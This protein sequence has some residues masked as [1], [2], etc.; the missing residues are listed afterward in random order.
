VRKRN[1]EA[2]EGGREEDDDDERSKRRCKEIRAD[3]GLQTHE[4]FVLVT[5]TSNL[6]LAP[7][8][9]NPNA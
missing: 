7:Q 6:D 1:G 3:E 8:R 9:L 2:G 5:I 4:V